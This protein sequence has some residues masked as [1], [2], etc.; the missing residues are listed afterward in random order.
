MAIP[1]FI[2]PAEVERVGIVGGGLGVDDRAIF[3]YKADGVGVAIFLCRHAHE[4]VRDAGIGVA[5]RVKPTV[6][7]LLPHELVHP[8]VRVVLAHQKGFFDK[9]R[10]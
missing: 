7:S 4:A 1:Q 2:Y 5:H 3:P 10:H 9:M 6:D 8:A